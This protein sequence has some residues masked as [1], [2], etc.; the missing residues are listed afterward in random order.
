MASFGVGATNVLQRLAAS[1][2]QLQAVEPKFQ[3]VN[4]VPCGGVLLALPALLV[5]GL[6]TD[7][8]QHFQ[9]PKGYYALH[10]IFLLLAC[11][12]LSRI[13]TIENLR[14]CSPGEWGKL[15]GLDRIPEV[16]TLREKIKYLSENG[17]LED[18]SS[19]LCVQWMNADSQ[20]ASV[21]YID[22][23]VRVYHGSQTA[24]PKHYVAR[25]KLCLRA[26]ID[27]WI[28]AR[29]GQ[30]FFFINKAVDPGLLQVLEHEIVPR[31]EKEVPAQP[32]DSQLETDPY[33]HR[34]T[35][36]FDREGYSPDFMK[37][38][39]EKHIACIT[40][41]KH[42]KE[43]WPEEEFTSCSIRT[44][45]GNVIEAKLAERGTLLC[46]QFW[47]REVRKLSENGHQTSIL[48]TDYRSDLKEVA[49]EMVDRWSQENFFKYMRQHYNLD[50]LI[51]YSLENIPDTTTVVNPEYRRLDGEARRLAAQ[52]SRQLAEFGAIHLEGNIDPENVENYQ[53]KKARL[54]ENI[55]NLQQELQVTKQQRKNVERHISISQLPEAEKFSRLSTASKHLVDTIKM[56]AYR[57][58][59][60]MANSLR[61]V[62]SRTDDARS[63][64]RA[65]YQTEVDLLPDEKNKTLTVTLHH[66][67][68]HSSDNAVQYLCNELNATNTI[69]P[70]TELQLIYKLGS[71]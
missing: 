69:F 47:V 41:H 50:R 64:L 63:L 5:C 59:T 51:D 65:V 25:E 39:K 19:K 57:A 22:G 55:E 16:R 53:S 32:N 54:Q 28:N 45:A 8:D 44:M 14:Y 12:A 35:L 31:L 30:P 18:W 11:M 23:H 61:E 58:E 7:V 71:S 17:H 15:L 13:K 27:Y 67:A 6:L 1:L 48:S 33:L 52:H 49:S 36:I 70:G 68:N 29:D 34:F 2:G 20:L 40:Y 37:R 60:A 24:L 38:M 43:N 9:L 21:F 62:M 10:S 42:P 46:K 66:L 4:D 26:T 56:I 3:P